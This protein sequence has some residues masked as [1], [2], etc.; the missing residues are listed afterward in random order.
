MSVPRVDLKKNKFDYEMIQFNFMNDLVAAPI[1]FNM[2]FTKTIYTDKFYGES[3]STYN[4]KDNKA[5]NRQ[6]V[7]TLSSE[8]ARNLTFNY[9]GMVNRY[10]LDY[11]RGG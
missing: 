4:D 3:R 5:N 1:E 9:N 7:N 8:F 10:T 2:T 6:D 11:P